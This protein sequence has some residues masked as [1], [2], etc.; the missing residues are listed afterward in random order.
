MTTT[1]T[2][3]DNSN[4]NQAPDQL[5][6]SRRDAARVLGGISPRTVDNHTRAGLLKATRIGGRKMYHVDELNRYAREG[7]K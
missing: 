7:S 4:L 5:L 3:Q 2:P 1:T 6:Y